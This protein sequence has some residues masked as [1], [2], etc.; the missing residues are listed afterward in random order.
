MEPVRTQHP[1][2]LYEAKVLRHLR[3]GTGI[4]EIHWFG[5]EGDQNIMVMDLLGPSL[6]DLF[7][8][9][10]RKLSLKTVLMVGEQMI[11][12]VEYAHSKCF[13]H[14][15][16]KPDNFLMGVN[17]KS[18]QAGASCVCTYM[19]VQMRVWVY[20][21][22]YIIYVCTWIYACIQTHA[23][24]MKN[25]PD[26][27]RNIFLLCFFR[28]HASVLLRQMYAILPFPCVRR[29]KYTSIYL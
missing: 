1:Q 14:R 18:H 22:L 27:R 4:P 17:R 20:T 28:V 13:L 15:D 21:C 8:Y 3:G 16:I 9:C 29:C 25:A 2:L 12:R 26:F 5:T 24:N 10:S 6:E 7:N 11:N 19:Y 23:F